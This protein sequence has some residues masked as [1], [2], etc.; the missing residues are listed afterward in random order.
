VKAEKRPPARAP[1][2]IAQVSICTGTACSGGSLFEGERVV[3]EP[4]SRARL[5]AAWK[6]HR[7]YGAVHL[8]FTGCLGCC[9]CA[10]VI[11][12]G[13]ARGACLQGQGDPPAI[14]A[15]LIAWASAVAKRRAWIDPPRCGGGVDLQRFS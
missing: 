13:Q 7:L 1:R 5:V 15:D 6:E 14:E 4:I 9:P 3:K 11:A 8:N 2:V 12:F 10:P